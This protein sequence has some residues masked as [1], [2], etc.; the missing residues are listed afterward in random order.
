MR[1]W[2]ALGQSR[3]LWCPFLQLG[4][5]PSARDIGY[6]LE[7]RRGD[8]LVA[9]ILRGIGRALRGHVPEV[10]CG[11]PAAEKPISCCEQI[12]PHDLVED[13]VDWGLL[14]ETLSFLLCEAP[15]LVSSSS[16]CWSRTQGSESLAT[17]RL[18]RKLAAVDG[19]SRTRKRGSTVG[20]RYAGCS[21]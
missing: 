20:I 5:F 4:S 10:V 15:G 9:T 2:T 11:G 1:S 21:D 3:G 13:P 8:Y 17:I 14:E 16:A 7:V 6:E 19:L 18:A 12:I